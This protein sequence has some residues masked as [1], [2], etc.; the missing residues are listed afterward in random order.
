MVSKLSKRR[1]KEF[2]EFKQEIED[3]IMNKYSIVDK[4][5]A[6]EIALKLFKG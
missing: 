2:I 6:T 5:E 1:I 3:Q 4:Q